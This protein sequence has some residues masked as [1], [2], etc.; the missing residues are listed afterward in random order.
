MQAGV[1]VVNRESGAARRWPIS[2]ALI[3]ALLHAVVAKADDPS[4]WEW[5]KTELQT[6][7]Q[8]LLACITWINIGAE[9]NKDDGPDTRE[10]W[11]GCAAAKK[12]PGH[13]PQLDAAKSASD[14]P[15]FE[16]EV[17]S[18]KLPL[19]SHKLLPNT[20]EAL[21]L[22]LNQATTKGIQ[23]RLVGHASCLKGE[24]DP[25]DESRNL[26]LSLQRARFMQLALVS[27]NY[28]RNHAV[29][30][31]RIVTEGRGYFERRNGGDFA[32]AE[33]K[34][35]ARGQI[36]AAESKE[37]LLQQRVEVRVGSPLLV[38]WGLAAT[39]QTVSRLVHDKRVPEN[40][41]LPRAFPKGLWPG[42]YHSVD[43]SALHPALRLPANSPR[44][45]WGRAT[46]WTV[47]AKTGAPL[48]HDALGVLSLRVRT[49]VRQ[50]PGGRHVGLLL[51]V[52][53]RL[54]SG[55]PPIP[56]LAKTVLS[57]PAYWALEERLTA[58]LSPILSWSASK[59]ASDIG[60]LPDATVDPDATRK[61]Q[62][63]QVLA[64][65]VGH[66]T[67]QPLVAAAPGKEVEDRLNAAL[68]MMLQYMPQT[69]ED[70][71]A[72]LSGVHPQLGLSPVRAG[73]RVCV[74]P[75]RLFAKENTFEFGWSGESCANVGNVGGA[76]YA[77]R[78]QLSSADNAFPQRYGLTD[79]DDH[80]PFRGRTHIRWVRTW[81]EAFMRPLP[82]RAVII[83]PVEGLLK[84]QAKDA[85]NDENPRHAFMLI[86][87]SGEGAQQ[88]V[89]ARSYCTPLP[90]DEPNPVPD[91]QCVTIPFGGEL[92]LQVPLQMAKGRA[93]WDLGLTIGE[94]GDMTGRTGNDVF[95]AARHTKAFR[96]TFATGAGLIIDR[97][98]G[99]ADRAGVLS[100]D[101]D[102]IRRLPVINGDTVPW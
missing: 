20:V 65:K 63:Y 73:E 85:L 97:S 33:C 29:S 64:R 59:I 67:C 42:M 95:S 17:G 54:P 92:R 13:S 66:T 50:T 15:R 90:D 25:T 32:S 1:D 43:L 93:F 11:R 49:A 45:C 72:R 75:S 9:G 4:E 36:A 79:L 55:D 8:N 26:H 88:L 34:K 30:G 62:F 76:G 51:D 47:F 91:A 98:R 22:L 5:G 24:A 39:N 37:E 21:G 84:V 60:T 44:E 41:L 102:F 16:F 2:L 80:W 78:L 7:L 101:T 70:M 74:H 86:G 38:R 81:A 100:G 12:L 68:G 40:A 46:P 57:L 18:D 48:D 61:R 56:L 83:R 19:H 31:H 96:S 28:T 77:P 94:L 69:H 99:V 89:D 6:D 82:E 58:V 52:T 14:F 71:L 3:F 27:Y 35:R 10:F 87:Y 53:G 23:I